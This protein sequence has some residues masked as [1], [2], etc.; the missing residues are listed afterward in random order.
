VPHNNALLLLCKL[1]YGRRVLNI[2]MEWL[3]DTILQFVI[4]TTIAL[5]ALVAT[6][7]SIR[8]QT[9]KKKISYQILTSNQL[10][11][12]TE[13]LKGQIEILFNKTPVRDIHL[14]VVK[15][16]NDGDV[17]ILRK[18]FDEPIKISFRKD[19]RILSAEIIECL[20]E[21]FQPELM[22]ET[23]PL[24]IIP[25]LINPQDSFTIKFLLSEFDGTMNVTGRVAGIKTIRKAFTISTWGQL[26]LVAY[27]T[28][29][30]TLT[31]LIVMAKIPW[32][33]TILFLIGVGVA[34]LVIFVDKLRNEL[35]ARGLL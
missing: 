33:S 4:T 17:P 22:T 35:R 31:L 21:S 23:M 19:T 28:F 24:Y 12:A 2:A 7:F 13:E 10:L 30:L 32:S 27:P 6:L 18:D 5:M 9:Y 16:M 15:F 25:T 3:Q 29:T 1:A 20:P 8:L 34:G 14:L 11:T 26:Y